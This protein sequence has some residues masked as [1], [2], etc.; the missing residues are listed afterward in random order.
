MVDKRVGQES[1]EEIYYGCWARVR[2]TREKNERNERE[3]STTKKDN[4]KTRERVYDEGLTRGLTREI[5]LH[6]I[7]TREILLH[8][9]HETSYNI[10]ETT[11]MNI[12]KYLILSNVLVVRRT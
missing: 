7:T 12:L 6:I 9:M 10:Y 4:E 2:R 11:F 5:L 3:T 8:I 1:D